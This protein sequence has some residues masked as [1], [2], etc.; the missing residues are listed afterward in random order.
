MVAGGFWLL[1]ATEGP[2]GGMCQ[3]WSGKIW[4]KENLAPIFQI[5]LNF[6]AQNTRHTWVL[7]SGCCFLW[8]FPWL[9]LFPG[10]Y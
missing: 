7:T 1:V 5:E 9:Q 10:G 3:I 8:T 6:L 4:C 2:G